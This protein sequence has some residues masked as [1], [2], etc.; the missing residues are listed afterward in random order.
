PTIV[1]TMGAVI[2]MRGQ[3]PDRKA[4]F[5]IGVAGP[6]AGLLATVVVTA[7]GLSLPPV[8]V[9]PWVLNAS[10]AIQ[11]QFHYPP[12]LYGIAMVLGEPLAYADASKVVNPVVIGGWVGMF[13]TFLNLIPTG[14]LDGGHILR[15]ILG[16]AQERVAPLV[17]TMLFGLA[18]Y[19][20][21]FAEAGQMVGLWILWGI[22]AMI[23][24]SFGSASP[25]DDSPLDRGRIAV[26]VF[27]F[28]LG[29][30][31]FTPVPIQVTPA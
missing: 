5:D 22:L 27:T 30:L 15:A 9:P 12:L 24:A 2:R 11:V 17:P 31:C 4:L 23:A 3:I 1:G 7:I 13:I 28:I 6:L 21:F 14:Q 18:A 16:P 19:L 26:G 29:L 10:A 25:I 8:E 20:Y